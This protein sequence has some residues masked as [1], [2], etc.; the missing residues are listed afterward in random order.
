MVVGVE[1]RAV[2]GP[3]GTTVVAVT[4]GA[5]M[6]EFPREIGMIGIGA[7]LDRADE[8]AGP[9]S[10]ALV[11]GPDPGGFV[12]GYTCLWRS[13]MAENQRV[14]T[15]HTFAVW[16]EAITRGLLRRRAAAGRGHHHLIA[17]GKG[18][19]NRDKTGKQ[20]QAGCPSHPRTPVGGAARRSL[21]CHLLGAENEP[22]RC[23]WYWPNT[24]A[25]SFARL[26]GRRREPCPVR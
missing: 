20:Q 19:D 1:Q 10:P 26:L 17:S 5:G 24:G 4:E 16:R 13:G 6:R 12:L 25:A 23:G 9:G 15:D 11:H 3:V 7:A 8:L 21:K 2:I 14:K 18:Q 22:G